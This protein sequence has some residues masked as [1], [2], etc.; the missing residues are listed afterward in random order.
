[1]KNVINNIEK[2][3]GLVIA[4]C[5]TPDVISVNLEK[6]VR[7]VIEKN[8]TLYIDCSFQTRN[9]IRIQTVLQSNSKCLYPVGQ[10]DLYLK[11]VNK[12]PIIRRTRKY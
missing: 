10:A 5:G 4:P 1:M 2:F 7:L 3:I 8:V 12:L 6:N 9:K 11:L